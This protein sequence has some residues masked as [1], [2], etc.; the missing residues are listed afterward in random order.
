M[1]STMS[2]KVALD[3]SKLCALEKYWHKKSFLPVVGVVARRPRIPG[4]LPE[5]GC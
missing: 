4:I 3:K 5:L 1:M 2:A